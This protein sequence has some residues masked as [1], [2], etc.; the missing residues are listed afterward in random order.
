MEWEDWIPVRAHSDEEIDC[1]LEELAALEKPAPPLSAPPRPPEKS[2]WK[3]ELWSWVCTFA[4]TA[5]AVFLVLYVLF[6]I[7]EVQGHSM[8]PTLQSGDRLVISG[9]FYF[10]GKTGAGAG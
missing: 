8:D 7:V 10:A 4:G 5:A 3:Q 2:G 9:L 6:R 1:I